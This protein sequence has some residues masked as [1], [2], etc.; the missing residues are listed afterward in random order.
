MDL[1]SVVVVALPSSGFC[2]DAVVGTRGSEAF[3][4]FTRRNPGEDGFAHVTTIGTTEAAHYAAAVLYAKATLL[5]NGGR[6]ST[7]ADWEIVSLM[8]SPVSGQ[9]PPMDPLTIAR[10]VLEK[11]GGTAMPVN[12]ELARQLAEAVIYHIQRGALHTGSIPS[13]PTGRD[14]DHSPPLLRFA[15]AHIPATTRAPALRSMHGIGPILYRGNAHSLL[16]HA[17]AHWPPSASTASLVTFDVPP[18]AFCCRTVRLDDSTLLSARFVNAPYR[19]VMTAVKELSAIGTVETAL[20]A[21][22]Y[23]RPAQHGY[24]LARVETSPL[25]TPAPPRPWSLAHAMLTREKLDAS[26]A[27]ALAEAI[28]HDSLRATH[29]ELVGGG[30]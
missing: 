1:E 3:A 19:G 13:L 28:Y 20:A 18:N 12:G 25:K 8:T 17:Q 2:C 26:D 7:S 9:P 30:P 11:P 27:S 6:R 23:F 14:P 22:L 4:T 15:N 21:R 5:E 24:A 29:S 10:N 16:Q